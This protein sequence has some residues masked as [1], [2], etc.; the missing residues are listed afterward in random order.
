L[1]HHRVLESVRAVLFKSKQFD[2]FARLTSKNKNFAKFL[3]AQKQRPECRKLDLEAFLIKPVQRIC[4][5][6]LLFRELIKYTRITHPDH[7]AIMRAASK[8]EEIATYVNEKRREAETRS[9]MVEIGKSFGSSDFVVLVPGRYLIREFTHV[10][11]L[12][13]GKHT[14]RTLFLFNDVLLVCRRRFKRQ[15]EVSTLK[16]VIPLILCAVDSTNSNTIAILNLQSGA[17]VKLLILEQDVREELVNLLRTAKQ[18]AISV[19]RR[20]ATQ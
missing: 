20:I 9:R 8:L 19:A 4:K 14:E 3:L 11:I 18:E 15:I 16:I 12:Q 17:I 13:S 1:Q 7:D 5:Y 2:E 6:P 10:A